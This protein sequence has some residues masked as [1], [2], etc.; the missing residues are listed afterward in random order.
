MLVEAAEA[1]RDSPEVDDALKA[2]REVL[3]RAAQVES[4]RAL[5]DR[6]TAWGETFH[7]VQA[8]HFELDDWVRTAEAAKLIH[9]SPKTLSSM[10]IKGRIKGV[11]EKNEGSVGRYWYKVRDVYDLAT[12]M[13]GRNY[14]RQKQS[15]DTLNDSET[16]DGK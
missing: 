9:V 14:W 8:E 16:G 15:T 13:P 5:D 1:G 6:F 4:V 11:Y 10:R 12:T 3:G 7:C 2:A